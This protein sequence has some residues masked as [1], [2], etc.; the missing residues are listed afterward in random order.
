MSNLWRGEGATK[1]RAG[2]E[3]RGVRHTHGKRRVKLPNGGGGGGGDGSL[4][5]TLLLRLWRRRI[6]FFERRERRHLRRCVGGGG[7][8]ALRDNDNRC[9]FVDATSVGARRVTSTT[10][11]LTLSTEVLQC[12]HAREVMRGK[13]GPVS[14]SLGCVCAII[15]VPYCREK[16]TR[17]C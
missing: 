11:L 2:S 6:S 12:A 3:R 5:L 9:A 1:K 10:A 4:T 16:K 13:G 14:V 15:I 17:E 8:G 7:G